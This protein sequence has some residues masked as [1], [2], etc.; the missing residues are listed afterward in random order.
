ML[1]DYQ[2]DAIN[3]F[4]NNNYNGILQMATGTGK[5]YTAINIFKEIFNFKNIIIVVAP[6]QHLCSQWVEEIEMVIPDKNVFECHSAI[7]N[8]KKEFDRKLDYAKDR[9]GMFVFCLASFYKNML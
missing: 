4:K 7:P 5:T 3:S 1:R 2:I 9:K 6:Y 8:W